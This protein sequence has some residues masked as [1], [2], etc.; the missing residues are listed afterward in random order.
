MRMARISVRMCKDT[1]MITHYT[2]T[3]RDPGVIS[4]E[5]HK[6]ESTTQHLAIE[7]PIS[8]WIPCG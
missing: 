7:T 1:C 3:L 2:D 8:N 6:I 4:V 5:I